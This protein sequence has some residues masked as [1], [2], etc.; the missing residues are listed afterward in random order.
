[1]PTI[2][3][4]ILSGST[5]GRGVEVVATGTAG[6][7]IHTATTGG[8]NADI[9]EVFIYATN[10]DTSQILLTIEF[11]GADSP[12]DHILAKV[13]AQTTVL[14]VPGLILKA[15]LEVRAFAGTANK[16]TCHGFV[17]RIDIS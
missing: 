8:S 1:M 14:V 15:G 6:T 3:K 5:N 17:N 4:E 2:A 10:I 11:G 13:P 16:I 12:D 7:L 9:D